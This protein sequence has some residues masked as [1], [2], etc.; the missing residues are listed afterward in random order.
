VSI[1]EL[2]LNQESQTKL[3]CILH[4]FTLIGGVF[5]FMMKHFFPKINTA[6]QMYRAIHDAFKDA[7]NQCSMFGM[8]IMRR[9]NVGVLRMNLI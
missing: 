5:H 6:L 1:Q 8:M 9:I 3:I 2:V 4:G 7:M